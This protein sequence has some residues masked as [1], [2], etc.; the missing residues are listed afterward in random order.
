MTPS[1]NS[2]DRSYAQ[3][4]RGFVF[5]AASW[6]LAPSTGVAGAPVDTGKVDVEGVFPTPLLAPGRAL[7][8]P[9]G[10]RVR[11]GLRIT[12]RGRRPLRFATWG[13]ILPELLDARGRV[14]DCA[15][16]ANRADADDEAYAT[17]PPG[18]PVTIR[19]AAVL[20]LK[21]SELTWE[22]DTGL[23][24]AWRVSQRDATYSLRLRYALA[25]LAQETSGPARWSGQTRSVPLPLDLR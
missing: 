22:D 13:A 1:D 8:T 9:A 15:C 6:V 11:L 24:G 25:G 23:V 7:W 3:G 17:A 5:A 21:G 19:L 10:A 16:G 2:G 4:R 20:R 14:V 12:N 18:R